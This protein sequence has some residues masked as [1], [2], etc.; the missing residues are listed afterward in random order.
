MAISINSIDSLQTYLNGVLGRAD[1]HAKNVEGVALSL[2]GAVIWRSTGE[3]SVREY[4]GHPANMLWFHVGPNKY[5]LT[6]NHSDETI[7]LKDRTHTGS[8]LASFDNSS[9][10][11]DII[12]IFK[13]L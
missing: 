9:S 8:V 5:V 1:H 4:N 6:Y 11:E 10:Y 3:I 2:I 7:E 13:S 12:S